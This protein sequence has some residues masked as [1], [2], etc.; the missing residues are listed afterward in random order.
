MHA[1]SIVEDRGRSRNSN[2]L[3]GDLDPFMGAALAQA[4]GGK[5]TEAIED[6]E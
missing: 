1:A 5:K 2:V 3:G 4:I 6:L